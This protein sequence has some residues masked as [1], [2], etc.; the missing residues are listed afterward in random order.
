MDRETQK[1]LAVRRV[2][3][4]ILSVEPNLR[5]GIPVSLMREYF[6]DDWR[7]LVNVT[8]NGKELRKALE[9][10]S[11]GEFTPDQFFI[12]VTALLGEASEI[13]RLN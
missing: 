13:A 6:I 5:Q 7:R 3:G 12:Y 10:Y 11:Q 8:Q 1:Y 9:D 2:W 4:D